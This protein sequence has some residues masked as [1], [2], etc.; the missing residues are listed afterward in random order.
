MNKKL[1]FSI[2]FFSLLF[3]VSIHAQLI[4]VNP[5]FGE[6]SKAEVELDTYP[7]DTTAS[8]LLLYSDRKV[9]VRVDPAGSLERE[10]KVRERW[11]VLKE[12]GKD[13]IDY[14]IFYSVAN[15]FTENVREIRATTFDL[16]DGQVVSH[17][18]S[19]KFVFDEPYSDG[20]KRVTFSPENVRLGSVV[21]VSF[22]IISPTID[23]GKVQ[24]QR[25]YPVNLAE[26]TVSFPDFIFYN[27]TTK[28]VLR[29]SRHWVLLRIRTIMISSA[30]R[31]SR[32]FVANLTAT[33]PRFTAQRSITMSG[34]S[35]FPESCTRIMQS[36]GKMWTTGWL[37]QDFWIA[38]RGLRN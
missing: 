27:T 22:I 14:E 33:A 18:M 13:E 16:V 7:L 12:S 9:S 15:N 20:V 4:Q 30:W 32:L 26:A 2:L 25:E 5:K 19:K 1:A 34:A 36:H 35:I 8:L 29:C 38:A 37:R 28:I 3:S 10:I 6:V 24:L 21:D 23:I 11:K 31:M 17:K